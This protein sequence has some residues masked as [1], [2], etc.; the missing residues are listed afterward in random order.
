MVLQVEPKANVRIFFDDISDFEAIKGHKTKLDK[1]SV[2]SPM[3]KKALIDG[4]L[5]IHDGEA[6]FR[7]KDCV[8]FADKTGV[9]K[10]NDNGDVLPDEDLLVK[11]II[12]PQVKTKNV[13]KKKI[14]NKKKIKKKKSEK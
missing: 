5:I 1:F 14:T 3:I 10:I 12:E 4:D 13:P 7:F 8:Y 6:K 2:R 9:V 11:E